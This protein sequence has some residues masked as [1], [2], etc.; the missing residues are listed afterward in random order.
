MMNTQYIC[1]WETK[2]NGM[3]INECVNHICGLINK[4]KFVEEAND[5]SS[6]M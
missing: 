3:P 1:P 4:D 6:M 5:L 2:M